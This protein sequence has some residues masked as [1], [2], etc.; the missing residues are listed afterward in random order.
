MPN[1]DVPATEQAFVDRVISHIIGR[2]VSRPAASTSGKPYIP[3]TGPS[4]DP[5]LFN[6][7]QD[8]TTLYLQS[9]LADNSETRYKYNSRLSA[10]ETAVRRHI[11]R[12]PAVVRVPYR[13]LNYSYNRQTQQNEGPDAGLINRSHR[14]MSLFQYHP[15]ALGQNRPG[16]RIF[17]EA[18][19]RDSTGNSGNNRIAAQAQ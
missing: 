7:D 3:P 6:G 14:G 4:V 15:N 16:W 8:G 9:P 19:Y 5:D 17:L 10:I 18:A 2:E 13:R 12:R 1:R 11:G